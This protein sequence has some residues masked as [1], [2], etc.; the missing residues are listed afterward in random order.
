MFFSSIAN[1]KCT[2]WNRQMYPW[3]TCT[4]R[5]EPMI[6]VL[7]SRILALHFFSLVYPLA[8]NKLYLFIFYHFP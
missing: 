2:P 4:T 1:L 8:Y 7:D 3:G 6:Q 5:W